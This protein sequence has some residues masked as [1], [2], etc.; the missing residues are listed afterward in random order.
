MAKILT[1]E[2]PESEYND[3]KSFIKD[4]SAEI[5]KSLEAMKQDQIEID[6]LRKESEKIRRKTER[7]K[8]ETRIYLEDLE[9]RVLKAA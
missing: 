1:F 5:H 2:I 3:L 9:K 7:L 8:S 4:C 6:R